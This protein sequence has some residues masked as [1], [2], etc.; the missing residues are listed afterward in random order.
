MK[1]RTDEHYRIGFEIGWDLALHGLQLMPSHGGAIID[2]HKAWSLSHPAGAVCRVDAR[3]AW[4]RK[5]LQVRSGAWQRRIKFDSEVT[6]DYLLS[7]TPER[8]P[9]TRVDLTVGTL[10]DSDWSL[11]R[12]NNDLGYVQGNIAVISSHANK[13]KGSM[14]ASQLLKDVDVVATSDVV[15]SREKLRLAALANMVV[16]NGDVSIPFALSPP[17]GVDA[18][19]VRYKARGGILVTGLSPDFW[20]VPRGW[21][22]SKRKLRAW[23][24][25][26]ESITGN[27]DRCIRDHRS[28]SRIDVIESLEDTAAHPVTQHFMHAFEAEVCAD[29]PEAFLEPGEVDRCQRAWCEF[30]RDGVR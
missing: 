11:D 10:C 30:A 2:G 23:K 3:S 6:P 7:I 16:P 22:N 18:F 12:V 15:N 24:A 8:C 20:G 14:S 17:K 1:C 28:K 29:N 27:Y 21:V 26:R 9:I 5:W 25:L 19:N 13:A 4:T